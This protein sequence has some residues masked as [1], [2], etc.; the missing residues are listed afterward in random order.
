MAEYEEDTSSSNDSDEEL[1]FK[2]QFLLAH[3]KYRQ[4]VCFC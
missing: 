1:S 4:K 2:K 3:N